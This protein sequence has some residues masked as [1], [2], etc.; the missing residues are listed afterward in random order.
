[1]R[2]ETNLTREHSKEPKQHKI[3]CRRAVGHLIINYFAKSINFS[4]GVVEISPSGVAPVCQIG[5]QLELTCSSYSRR[6][7]NMGVQCD[8]RQ[9]INSN[10]QA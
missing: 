8:V 2:S 9:R 10:L 7:Q 6:I 3:L 4:S 5:D 1:M